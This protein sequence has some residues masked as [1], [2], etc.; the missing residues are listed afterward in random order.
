MGDKSWT[1]IEK[2]RP[3]FS[4]QHPNLKT[5]KM[6]RRFIRNNYNEGDVVYAKAHP[7]VR[8]IIRRYVDQ[9][10]YCKVDNDSVGNERVYFERELVDDQDLKAKNVKGNVWENEGGSL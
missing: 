7:D 8:L 10:Y 4:E 9:V 3:A 5:N 2:Y 1:D 6:S